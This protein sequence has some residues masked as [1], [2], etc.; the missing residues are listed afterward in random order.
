MIVELCCVLRVQ[1]GG[2]KAPSVQAP[3]GD[4]RNLGGWAGPKWE[5]SETRYRVSYDIRV[6]ESVQLS[7]AKERMK[8]NH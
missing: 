1:R 7:A 3:R 8:G 4:G 2:G 5:E 6:C